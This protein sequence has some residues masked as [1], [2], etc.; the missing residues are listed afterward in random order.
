MLT[1][2]KLADEL[3]QVVRNVATVAR[4]QQQQTDMLKELASTVIRLFDT[5]DRLAKRIEMLE[6]MLKT[7]FAENPAKRIQKIEDKIESVEH[8]LDLVS[9]ALRIEITDL[10][11]SKKEDEY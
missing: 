5:F 10:P 6:G 7:Y 2:V 4:I 11:D 9:D 3:A 1:L 8:R